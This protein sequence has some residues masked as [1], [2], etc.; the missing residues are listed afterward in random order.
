MAMHGDED[1]F[2]E[3]SPLLTRVP[4]PIICIRSSVLSRAKDNAVFMVYLITV[5]VAFGEYLLVALKTQIY[6]SIVC[7]NYYHN[8]GDDGIA[9]G[10]PYGGGRCKIRAVQEELA[11]LRGLEQLTVMVLS[12]FPILSKPAFLLCPLTCTLAVLAIPYGVFAERY[13]RGLV[14]SLA[15]L[16]VLLGETWGLIV[17]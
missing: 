9:D 7:R 15:I 3:R 8:T 5:I 14:L 17:C 2:G 6:E 1:E 11:L 16:G 4:A 10:K 13:G 12:R